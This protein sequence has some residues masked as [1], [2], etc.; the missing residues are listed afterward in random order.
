MFDWNPIY[1]VV[2]IGV[3]I[4]SFIITTYWN[5]RNRDDH[6]KED[7][8]TLE[9]DIQNDAIQ[10]YKDDKILAEDLLSKNKQIVES[11]KE[12]LKDYI[13]KGDLDSKRELV[14]AVKL[15]E[16]DI[17][18]LQQFIFGKESKSLPAYLKGEIDT[19]EHYAEEGHGIF[20]DT[21]EEAEDRTKG[22]G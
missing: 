19:P 22:N 18:F 2:T 13:D 9:E 12:D 8:R 17:A 14:Y 5:K 3:G 16:K 4:G 15:L 20:Q 1:I 21:E 10:K 6:V 11:L 7:R